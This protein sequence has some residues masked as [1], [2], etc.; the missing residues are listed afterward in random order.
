LV[1]L[2]FLADAL[3]EVFMTKR[4]LFL[5]FVL[6][7]IGVPLLTAQSNEVL[8]SVLGEANISYGNAA[9][10]VGTASGLFPET[11]S[12]AD[13]GP[14]LEQKGWGIQ[15]RGPTD[16]VTLG[17]FSYMLSRAFDIHSS[18]MYWV[19][20]G[21]RYATRELAYLG[22]ISGPAKPGMA[23]SGERALRILEQILHRREAT[24]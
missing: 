20:P 3:K 13:A 5:M 11:T 7:A 4:A 14:L 22:I 24:R 6:A 15:G 9:Y 12:P 10:L 17:D 18:L 2:L 1:V 8:D 19:L 16:P 21:P 23:L